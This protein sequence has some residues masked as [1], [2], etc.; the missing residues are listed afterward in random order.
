MYV[1]LKRS[2][3]RLGSSHESANSQLSSKTPRVISRQAADRCTAWLGQQPNEYGKNTNDDVGPVYTNRSEDDV[4]NTQPTICSANILSFVDPG[5]G[6]KNCAGNYM[7]H[8]I[9]R[10]DVDDRAKC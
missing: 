2:C 9:Q 6:N 3:C 5:S 4:E 7:N 1:S 10:R 8:S